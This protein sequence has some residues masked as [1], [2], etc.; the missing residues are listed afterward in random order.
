MCQIFLYGVLLAA[1]ACR[2]DTWTAEIKDVNVV[3]D[4]VTFESR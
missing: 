1:A 3:K 4:M 2:Q